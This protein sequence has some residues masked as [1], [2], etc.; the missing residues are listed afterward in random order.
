MS[1][2]A[3]HDGHVTYDTCLMGCCPVSQDVTEAS[4]RLNKL[5]KLTAAHLQAS[6][7]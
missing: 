2:A 3:G 1:N 7:I 5:N 6:V 4:L